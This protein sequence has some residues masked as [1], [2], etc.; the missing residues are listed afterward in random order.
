MYQKSQNSISNIII[1]F[2]IILIVMKK[3]ERVVEVARK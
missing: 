3:E 2:I 1:C